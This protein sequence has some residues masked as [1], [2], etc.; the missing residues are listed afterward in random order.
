MFNVSG[1]FHFYT[2]TQTAGTVITQLI[3]PSPSV[4]QKVRLTKIVY[5]PGATVH[6]LILM[7]A[8][9]QVLTTAAAAA[10]ATTIVVDSSGFAGQT[11]ASGDYLVVEHADGTCGLYLASALATL[12][13]TINALSKA[14]NSGARVWILGSISET[15]HSTLPTVAS[16]RNDFAEPIGGLA[17]SG[18][19]DGTSYARDGRGEPMVI[20][21][22]NAT[23]A[24]TLNHGT[25]I[26]TSS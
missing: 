4:S 3:P 18:W 25:A 11:I 20:Y 26:Y 9:E 13:V 21:S 12:T 5:T 14:V 1:T 24:G 15:W 6:N 23:N 22:A 16:I 19:D 17:Q 10:S 8:A 2:T 7:R